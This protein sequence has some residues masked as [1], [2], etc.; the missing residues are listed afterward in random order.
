[1]NINFLKRWNILGQI[2]IKANIHIK[3]PT[4]ANLPTIMQLGRLKGFRLI[5]ASTNLKKALVFFSWKSFK[6]LW[7]EN[8]KPGKYN[9]PKGTEAFMEEV[10]VLEIFVE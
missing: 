2:W 9:P 3:E 7:G 4:V 6:T 10:E 5:K 8:P 1:M